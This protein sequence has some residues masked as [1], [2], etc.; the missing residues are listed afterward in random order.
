MEKRTEVMIGGKMLPIQIIYKRNKH[1]YLRVQ[2]DGSLKITCPLR[3][4][5]DSIRR[6]L[7]EKEAWIISAVIHRKKA[8]EIHKEGI[9]GPVIYWLGEKKYVR[10]EQSKKDYMFIDGDILTFYLRDMGEQRIQRVFRK[11]ASARLEEMILE[12]RVLWDEQICRAGRLP[13]PEINLKHMKSR[14][15]VCYPQK[16][17]I[18]L[19]LRLIHYPE[20]AFAYVLLHEYVHLLVPNHSSDFYRIVQRFMPHYKEYQA[21]LK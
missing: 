12:S 7:H 21:L 8:E 1:M 13:L 15:G 2:D 10:Y 9:S 20:Q 3:T 19:S 11:Y 6:F 16:R 18:T 5:D 4:A 17:R 14:W